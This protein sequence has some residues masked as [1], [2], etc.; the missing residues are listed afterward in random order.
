MSWARNQINVSHNAVPLRPLSIYHTWPH[1]MLLTVL[2]PP[3]CLSPRASLFV[4]SSSCVVVVVV[5]Q[6]HWWRKTS[7]MTLCILA[8]CLCFHLQ[9]KQRSAPI[10]ACVACCHPWKLMHIHTVGIGEILLNIGNT[11]L[12][13]LQKWTQQWLPDVAGWE[14]DLDLFLF[15]CDSWCKF[16]SLVLIFV[17]INTMLYLMSFQAGCCCWPDHN[18]QDRPGEWGGTH[19]N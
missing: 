19:S 15:F 11:Q 8:L 4:S 10:W 18:Q 2:L 9:A 1:G 14:D 13:L 16:L 6:I 17:H 3:A 12:H 7:C 5:Q